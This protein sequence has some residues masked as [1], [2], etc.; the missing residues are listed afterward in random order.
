MNKIDEQDKIFTYSSSNNNLSKAYFL[1]HN[2]LGDN[3]TSIGAINFLL[4]YYDIIYFLCKNIHEKNVKLFFEKKSV[5]IIPFDHNNEFNEC[6]YILDNARKKDENINIFI[7]GC[8]KSYINSFITNI[9]LLNYKK[10]N[11]NYTINYNFI[12]NFYNDI[13]LDLSIYYEY[14]DIESSDTSKKYYEDIKNYDII[15][16]HTKSSNSEILLDDIVN[17]YI[18]INSSIIICANKNFY[19]KDNL[20]YNIAEKYINILIAY[21][22]DII[23]NSISIYVVDSCFSCI[24]YPLLKTNRLKTSNVNIINRNSGK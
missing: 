21:Y 7:C 24:V 5:I 11:K 17:K 13:N 22:I 23:K 8:H 1:S 12:E 20:K 10:S 9:E 3:I 16:M 6:K 18:N 4:N 14:F 15:F 19:K 2:G